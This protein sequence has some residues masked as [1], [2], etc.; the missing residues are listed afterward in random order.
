MC[1]DYRCALCF[2]IECR[3]GSFPTALK[4]SIH[5]IGVCCG[6]NRIII[7]HRQLSLGVCE[8]AVAAEMHGSLPRRPGTFG[9]VGLSE[10]Y[11]WRLG[12][13]IDRAP[14]Q[15]RSRVLAVRTMGA[16]HRLWLTGP[17]GAMP[18]TAWRQR[19]IRGLPALHHIP[20]PMGE[21]SRRLQF[22]PLRSGPERRIGMQAPT[23][24]SSICVS[25]CTDFSST[26][27]ICEWSIRSIARSLLRRSGRS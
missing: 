11:S 26:K 18:R 5:T 24:I 2:K 22:A 13:F 20:A 6:S 1:H 25:T 8:T 17:S 7:L 12:G 3:E 9:L 19:T 4:R 21:D 23:S 16:K 15:R 27:S 10:V 14:F